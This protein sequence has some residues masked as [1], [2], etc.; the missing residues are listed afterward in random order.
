MSSAAQQKQ[1]QAAAFRQKNE[2]ALEALN[3]LLREGTIGPHKF[4]QEFNKLWSSAGS[5]ERQGWTGRGPRV[6]V[7]QNQQSGS[8]YS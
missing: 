2:E 3:Q 7:V 6:M 5:D 4:D 1:Q 8:E